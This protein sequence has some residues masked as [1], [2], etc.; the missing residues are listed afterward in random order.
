ME[1]FNLESLASLTS[2]D[3]PELE[4]L[5]E[6]KTTL[7]ALMPDN[8]SGFN[9]LA[10]ILYTQLFQQLFHSDYHIYGS[11]P[12]PVHFLMDEFANKTQL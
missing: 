7:F 3:E 11:L 10:S 8:E 6:K 5:G 1:K 12:I 4:T 2:T 9:F